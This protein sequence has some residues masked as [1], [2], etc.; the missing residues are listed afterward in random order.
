MLNPKIKLRQNTRGPSRCVGNWGRVALGI[1][2]ESLS[3]RC[4]GRGKGVRTVPA[5]NR[6][7]RAAIR[8]CQSRVHSAKTVSRYP[9]LADSM[10]RS[11]TERKMLRVLS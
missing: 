1:A 8:A 2:G 4:P 6:A 3:S 7:A 11:E 5:V 10:Q 9:L